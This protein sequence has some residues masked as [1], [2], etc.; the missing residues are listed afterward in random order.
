MARTRHT[1]GKSLA[2]QVKSASKKRTEPVGR[3]SA[4]LIP[5][6]STL[7]NLACSG[8]IAGAFDTGEVINIIGDKSAGK[9]FLFFTLLAAVVQSKRFDK[10]R[11]I[12]DD[13]EVADRFNIR[14]LYGKKLHKRLENPFDNDESSVT[15]QDFDGRITELIEEGTPFVYGLDSFDA[16]TSDEEIEKAKK[17]SKAR[18]AG[19]K[20]A[21]SYQLDTTRGLSA[22]F[23]RITS[24][25]EETNSLLIVISQVRENIGAMPFAPKYRRNG[26]RALGHYSG[27][28]MWLGTVKKIK[29]SDR[30]VGHK[31]QVR[32]T[33]NKL[34]GKARDIY[35]DIYPD[36]GIDDIGS[37][38]DFMVDEKAWRKKGD[39]IRTPFGDMSRSSL[40]N[41]IEEEGLEDALREAVGE[42]WA[43]IEE[44]IRTKRKKRFE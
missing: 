36:Y 26:G 42:A 29:R 6:G 19:K 24:G 40:I 11:T 15:I 31:C 39:K 44:K 33:K 25:L 37:C 21:G 32:V 12:H 22:M 8:N 10:Y 34:T 23:R 30:V 20:E 16:L 38:V 5:T 27:H 35:F 9:T 3:K 18:A 17:K 2:D 1:K 41:H 4:I 13:A 28:E 7:L 43:E 14:K